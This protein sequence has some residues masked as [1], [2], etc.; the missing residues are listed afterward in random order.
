MAGLLLMI[1]IEKGCQDVERSRSGERWGGIAGMRR[2]KSVGVC[3]S[4]DDDD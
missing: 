4:V 1:E 2:I 3:T